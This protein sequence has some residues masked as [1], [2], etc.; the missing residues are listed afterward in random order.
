MSLRAE[1]VFENL[2]NWMEGKQS[3]GNVCAHAA[4]DLLAVIVAVILT[5][6]QYKKLQATLQ[7]NQIAGG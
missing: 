6:R 4:A 7:P 5:L 3:K 2:A 1:I